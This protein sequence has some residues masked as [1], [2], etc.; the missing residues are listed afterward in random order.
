[1]C[2]CVVKWARGFKFSR[3]FFSLFFL[4]S[5]QVTSTH[6]LTAPYTIWRAATRCQ[7]ENRTTGHS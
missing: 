2:R 6:G 1:M 7:R 5:L 4:Q 3:F